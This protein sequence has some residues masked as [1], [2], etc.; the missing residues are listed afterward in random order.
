LAK[1]KQKQIRSDDLSSSIYR[2][3][4]IGWIGLFIFLTLGIVLETLHGFK[5]EYYLDVR[6]HS[7]RLMW[8]LAHAHGSLFSLIH[9]AY[10]AT[11]GLTGRPS[12]RFVS[13]CLAMALF[14]LPTGFFLGGIWVY[15]GDPGWG[16]LLV[17]LGAVCLLFGVGRFC[18]SLYSAKP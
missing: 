16:I 13:V 2:H 3:L 4:R 7:R 12:D 10:A 5:S 17:P 11:L 18:V 15:D 9:I 14:L 6:N 8:T 1:Q